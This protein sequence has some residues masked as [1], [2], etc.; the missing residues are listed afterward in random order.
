MGS[1]STETLSLR[2]TWS[3]GG[4][5]W[6]STWILTAVVGSGWGYPGHRRAIAALM[7]MVRGAASLRRSCVGPVLKE[8]QEVT[9]SSFVRMSVSPLM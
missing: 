4:D 3:E 9:L 8:D 2:S 7:G 6:L 1:V 5:R